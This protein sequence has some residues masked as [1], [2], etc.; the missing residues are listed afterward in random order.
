MHTCHHRYPKGPVPYSYHT[1]WQHSTHTKNKIQGCLNSYT[2]TDHSNQTKSR[3]EEKVAGTST[4][5]ET[6]RRDGCLQEGTTW[7]VQ[8][9]RNDAFNKETTP[10]DAVAVGLTMRY[11]VLTLESP[12]HLQD[13]VIQKALRRLT[14][15]CHRPSYNGHHATRVQKR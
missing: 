2:T 4:L 6:P 9:N 7:K 15:H 13:I 12:V 3:K 1:T 5:N 14:H 11:R 10:V 8:R